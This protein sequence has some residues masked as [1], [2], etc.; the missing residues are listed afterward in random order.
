MNHLI[1]YNHTIIF[2]FATDEILRNVFQRSV[3][4]M[5]KLV[6]ENIEDSDQVFTWITID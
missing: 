5:G 2:T 3:D 4:K 1:L 6:V